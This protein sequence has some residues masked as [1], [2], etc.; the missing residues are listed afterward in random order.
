MN[1]EDLNR[2]R[3]EAWKQPERRKRSED[4]TEKWF[5]AVKKGEAISLQDL[6]NSYVKHMDSLALWR[7]HASKEGLR[8]E[9]V[10]R[11][12]CILQIHGQT[13]IYLI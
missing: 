3:R 1:L 4:E 5:E 11:G 8:R 7:I 2:A 12:G 9:F 13:C 10:A 6:F